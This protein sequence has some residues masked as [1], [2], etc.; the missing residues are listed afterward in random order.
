MSTAPPTLRWLLLLVDMRCLLECATDD[1]LASLTLPQSR[2]S[3]LGGVPLVF[4][5]GERNC[6]YTPLF[7]VPCDFF[8]CDTGV[9]CGDG[10]ALRPIG[11]R[12]MDRLCSL[13]SA[14][15]AGGGL[16]EI[17]MVP[18]ENGASFVSCASSFL[19]PK[20]KALN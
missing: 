13:E 3:V 15:V 5:R 2:L 19:G 18:C 7:C 8:C 11:L 10:G 20:E 16:G 6:E 12:P 1:T 14:R 17:S 4:F 9:F